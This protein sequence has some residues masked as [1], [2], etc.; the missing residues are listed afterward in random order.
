[1]N[2]GM[3]LGDAF[4]TFAVNDVREVER[5]CCYDRYLN[6]CFLQLIT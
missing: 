4:L 2:Y 6:R 1:M 3:E 5:K